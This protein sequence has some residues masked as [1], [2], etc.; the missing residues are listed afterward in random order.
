MHV[1]NEDEYI[2]SMYV[3]RNTKGLNL[4]E[5]NNQKE[6]NNFGQTSNSNME[7]IEKSNLLE[8]QMDTNEKT[9][10]LFKIA[11]NLFSE[12]LQLNSKVEILEKELNELKEKNGQYETEL[13]LRNQKMETEKKGVS[14]EKNSNPFIEYSSKKPKIKDEFIQEIKNIDSDLLGIG[15]SYTNKNLIHIYTKNSES[16]LL[17]EYEDEIKNNL[18]EIE[19]SEREDEQK[20]CFEI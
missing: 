4:E 20:L 11:K 7:E 10:Q 1:T 5:S 3:V 15:I 2:E 9:V 19:I 13:N 6:P 12:N 8:Q 17:A 18:I 14:K 16:K